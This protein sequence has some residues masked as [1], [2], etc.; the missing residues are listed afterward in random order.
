[1]GFFFHTFLNF[2][3]F[4]LTTLISFSV[5]ETI[6]YSLF[7]STTSS[8]YFFFESGSYFMSPLDGGIGGISDCHKAALFWILWLSFTCKDKAAVSDSSVS[9]VFSSSLCASE[10][11]FVVKMFHFLKS[12]LLH[13]L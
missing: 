1:M 6:F 12:Q 9:F 5:M 7:N 10:A 3:I 13:V 2:V 4:L 8:T 11:Y